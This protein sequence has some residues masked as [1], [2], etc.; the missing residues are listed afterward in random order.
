MIVHKD[1]APNKL[2]PLK[3]NGSLYQCHGP[4]CMAWRNFGGEG[5]GFCGMASQPGEIL[6]EV[7]EIARQAASTMG[8]QFG[9]VDGFEQLADGG[10]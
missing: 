7:H 3:S 4:A 9:A 10:R 1:S 8:V 5:M 6:T 2:C